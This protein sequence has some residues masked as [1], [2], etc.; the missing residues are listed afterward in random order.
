MSKLTPS[1]LT[2]ADG[3]PQAAVVP[4]REWEALLRERK[5]MRARELARRQLKADLKL[6]FAEVLA[7]E[8]GDKQLPT[9][10]AV[11]QSL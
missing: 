4:I 8:R 7:A 3:Q 6:A 11:L 1:Y 10:E 2:D 5:R 9:L